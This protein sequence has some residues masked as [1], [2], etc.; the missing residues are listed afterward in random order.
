MLMKIQIKKNRFNP[1]F[2]LLIVS[3]FA[4]CGMMAYKTTVTEKDKLVANLVHKLVSTTHYNQLELNNEFSKNAFQSLMNY[5]DPNKRFLLQADVDELKKHELKLDDYFINSDLS[6]FD[7]FYPLIAERE[8]EAG[9]LVLELLSKKIELRSVEDIQINA[10]SLN[11]CA[12]KKELKERWKQ[13]LMFMINDRLFQLEKKQLADSSA[14]QKSLEELEQEARE[15][16]KKKHTE[17]FK[18]LSQLEKADRLASYLNSIIAVY[19]PHSGY[20][21]PKDKEDFDIGFS[22]KLEGIG[23]TL[24]MKEGYINVEKIVPGSASWKA[25]DLEAGDLILEVAQGDEPP[26]DV[27]DMRLDKAVRLIRGP[28]GTEV[29]L[30]IKKVSGDVEVISII[31]DVVIIEETYAKSVVI[32][33]TSSANVYGY[34]NLASFYADF[35][36]RNGR[37][38]SKDVLKEL[39]ALKN[40]GVQG[41]ILDLRNNGGGSLSDAIKMAGY[42][43]EV[44]PVVQVDG[45]NE[46][47]KVHGDINPMVQF[48]HPLVVLVNQYSASASEIFAAAIQDYKRGVIM[49][50]NTFGKGTVQRF[51]SLEAVADAYRIEAGTEPLGE[52]KE[53]I[54]K[55]FRIDGGAT[56]LRGVLPDVILPDNYMLLDLGE[57]SYDFAMRWKE[58]PAADYDTFVY[59]YQIPELAKE[60]QSKVDTSVYFNQVKKA[61]KFLKEGSDNTLYT[62]DYESFKQNK[63]RRDSLKKAIEQGKLVLKDWS[64]D[65]HSKDKATFAT[66]SISKQ[67]MEAF[68]T[69]ITGDMYIREALNALMKMK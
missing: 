4:A 56:Q 6:L 55:F 53:T 20:Y 17:W 36:N 60:L 48:E 58:I 19:G 62:S 8:K 54:A 34:I 13:N 10:D 44:G 32:K 1:F 27:Y 64:I 9:E 5:T 51:Y 65:F 45:V 68:Q 50:T 29:R 43:I 28:K 37:T 61:A 2:V 31:R 42:F 69:T 25:G 30:T 24:S 12:T 67:R 18:R 33:D 3:C 14:E 47:P 66:D 40:E 7:N 57:S 59:Q 26:V 22:G 49:G 52:V 63:N 39:N 23:A 38:C 11:Y 35:N 21:P 46:A 41:V 15:H 16:V